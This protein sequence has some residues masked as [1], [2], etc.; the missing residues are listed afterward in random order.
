VITEAYSAHT[1]ET[2][3]SQSR[4]SEINHMWFK[5]LGESLLYF[6][7]AIPLDR[8]NSRLRTLKMGGWPHASNG[9]YIYLLEVFF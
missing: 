3:S 1:L 8:N 6:A 4:H 9:V 5:W 7:P 2:S